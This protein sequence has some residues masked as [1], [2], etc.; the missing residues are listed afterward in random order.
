[1]RELERCPGGS[2]GQKRRP[3]GSVSTSERAAR[4]HRLIKGRGSG[5]A[6][7]CCSLCCWGLESVQSARR[8][9]GLSE[10]SSA[11]AR[12]GGARRPRGRS[13]PRAL[14]SPSSERRDVRRPTSAAREKGEGGEARRVWSRQ[15]RGSAL[16]SGR[17]A[18]GRRRRRPTVERSRARLGPGADVPQGRSSWAE[19]ERR[20]PLREG[21]MGRHGRPG[22]GQAVL[23][24]RRKGQRGTRHG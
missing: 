20:G 21:G 4:D 9:A 19:I 5:S 16:G 12:V 24:G 7:L 17:R 6:A 1:M 11:G 22:A 13:P 15:P 2:R 8:R 18:E 3:S 23:Q 14:Q 10:I